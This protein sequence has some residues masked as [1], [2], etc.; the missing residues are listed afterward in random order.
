MNDKSYP[1]FGSFMMEEDARKI[2]GILQ[3]KRVEFLRDIANVISLEPDDIVDILGQLK[4]TIS[5]E[6]GTD[7]ARHDRGEKTKTR[8]A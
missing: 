6:Q 5:M 8:S 3:K 2:M 4:L 7:G 1:I